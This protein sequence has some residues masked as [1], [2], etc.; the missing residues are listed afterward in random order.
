MVKK[1]LNDRQRQE[2]KD[3]LK[4]RPWV[5]PSYV[6]GLRMNAK[7]LDFEQMG[8]DLI[9]LQKLAELDISTG[10]KSN[11]YKELHAEM[12]IQHQTSADQ[13]AE[14]EVKA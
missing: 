11:N 5:M 8:S 9:L 7:K 13:K 4:D 6:R 2:V 12:N 3:Y 14:F 1:I 10:R